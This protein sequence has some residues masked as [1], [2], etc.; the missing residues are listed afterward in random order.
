MVA[1]NVFKWSLCRCIRNRLKRDKGRSEERDLKDN[2]VILK[3]AAW[4]C[5]AQWG[6][7]KWS[8]SG[9]ILEMEP[10]GFAETGCGVT[11]RG[12]APG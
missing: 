8:N 4:A 2:S 7:N 9:Y 3:R 6:N 1:W 10:T 11:S 12:L 5:W